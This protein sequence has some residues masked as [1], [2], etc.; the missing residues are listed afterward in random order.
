MACPSLHLC[1]QLPTERQCDPDVW[2]QEVKNLIELLDRNHY[3]FTLDFRAT[4]TFKEL[5]SPWQLIS[6]Q[7][8][9]GSQI[10]TVGYA[11]NEYFVSTAHGSAEAPDPIPV[12]SP[13]IDPNSGSPGTIGLA[14]VIN[15]GHV[16]IAGDEDEDHDPMDFSERVI[17][18]LRDCAVFR[19]NRAHDS[20]VR[21]SF[22]LVTDFRIHL[23][24]NTLSRFY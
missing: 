5:V 24:D 14:E 6:V 10:Q 21:S 17:P 22:P 18:M 20:L 15:Y 3:G 7:T 8:P 13:V 19:R 11:N 23:M 9:N 16:G 12:G 4:H 2:E 1:F